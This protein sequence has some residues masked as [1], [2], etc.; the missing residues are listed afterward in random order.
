MRHRPATSLVAAVLA[1]A[2]LAAGTL[3]SAPAARAHPST[4]TVTAGTAPRCG[5]SPSLLYRR[6][7]FAD[8]FSG[9]R[10]DPDRWTITRTAATG[11]MPEDNCLR[12]DGVRVRGGLLE[13]TSQVHA[14]PTACTRAHARA[15]ATRLTGAQVTSRGKFATTYGMVEFRAAFPAATDGNHSALWLYPLKNTYGKWPHSGEI[16]VDERFPWAPEVAVQSLH[17]ADWSGAVSYT[18]G[19]KDPG[20]TT[21]ACLTAHPE[22]FNVYGVQWTPHTIS[23]TVNGRACG[24]FTW[25]PVLLAPPAPFNRPFFA[26]ATQDAIANAATRTGS[27]TTKVDWISVWH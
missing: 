20:Q 2:G 25:R 26:L 13:L 24:T 21:T 1:A 3:A 7:V 14:T 10:L 15:R 18:T 8:S 11:L 12:T 27:R 6:C 17:Y 9:T 22:R 19:D 5:P 23:F 4:R 16:D